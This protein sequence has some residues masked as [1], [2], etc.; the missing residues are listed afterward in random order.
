[1]SMLANLTSDAT[2]VEDKD[3]LGGGSYVL[4]SGVYDMTIELA[5]LAKSQEGAL[6]LNLQLKHNNTIVRQTLWLTGGNAK[7]NKNYYLNKTGEKK[8]LPGFS[9]ANALSLLTVKKE[10]NQ[11]QDEPKVIKLYDYTAKAEVPTKVDMLTELLGQTISIG[12]LKQ[13]VDKN[14][15]TSDGTYVPSG[16]TREENEIDRLFRASD[17]KT[18]NEIKDG[19]DPGEFRDAW[20]KKWTGVTKQ[21]AKGAGKGG[22]APMGAVSNAAAPAPRKSLFDE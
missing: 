15:K 11:I 3:T 5:Y 19:V 20:A 6:S 21:K 18:V 14:V 1:M 22:P 8:Y 4:E 7:G 17:G 16:E 10:I 2:I 9:H 13:V 12:L